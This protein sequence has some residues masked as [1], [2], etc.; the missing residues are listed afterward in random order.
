MKLLKQRGLSLSEILISLVVISFILVG[1]GTFLTQSTQVKITTF[2]HGEALKAHNFALSYIQKKQTLLLGIQESH[3]QRDR[4]TLLESCLTSQTHQQSS[5]EIYTLNDMLPFRDRQNPQS[6]FNAQLDS[7]GHPCTAVNAQDCHFLVR[8]FFKLHCVEATCL[9]ADVRVQTS[10]P[11]LQGSRG[12]VKLLKDD[13]FRVSLVSSLTKINEEVPCYSLQNPFLKSFDF[14]SRR[15]QC[16]VCPEPGSDLDV[17]H[18]TV[19]RSPGQ[20]FMARVLFNPD[21]VY[22]DD[23]LPSEIQVSLLLSRQNVEDIFRNRAKIQASF[24]NHPPVDYSHLINNNSDSIEFDESGQAQLILG[25][26]PLASLMRSDGSYFLKVT[27]SIYDYKRPGQILHED[28]KELL[29]TRRTP[30]STDDG[31]NSGGGGSNGGGTPPNTPPGPSGP[32][33]YVSQGFDTP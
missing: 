11:S 12:G 32:P 31:G 17:C 28:E 9:Y 22:L 19:V 18:G 21:V 29:F 3:P 14:Y 7:H 20:S 1:V 10:R 26:F 5:C 2:A 4:P 30:D 15:K 13:F 16:G 6:H 33:P 25:S 27:F 23:P 24:G 8:S